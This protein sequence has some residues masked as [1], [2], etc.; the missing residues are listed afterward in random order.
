MAVPTYTRNREFP[1]LILKLS[2]AIPATQNLTQSITNNLF[3]L[4]NERPA[5]LY[6]AEQLPH[7]RASVLCFG[8]RPPFGEPNQYAAHLMEAVA[9]FEPRLAR[10]T[11]S[12]SS[13]ES[14]AKTG[15]HWFFEV[16]ALMNPERSGQPFRCVVDF[17]LDQDQA[18]IL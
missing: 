7:V 8:A 10:E 1:D 9:I 18:T 16:K 2:G 3:S 5:Y 4:F 12:I 6:G 14:T 17:D 15:A 13:L 11:L